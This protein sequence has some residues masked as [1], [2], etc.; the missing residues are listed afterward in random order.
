MAHLDHVSMDD[1]RETLGQIEDKVPAQRVLTAIAYKQGD[2]IG[3]L[4]ERHAVSRQ[5]IRNWVDR[6][7]QRPLDVAPF[8]EPRAGRPRKLSTTD[9]RRFQRE[10]QRSP[11]RVGYDADEWTPRLAQQHLE[12]TY[13]VAYSDRHVRRL[14][15]ESEMASPPRS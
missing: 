9:R 11:R 15:R 12:T 3:R 5:T 2:S 8:D 7:A 13:G 1:L 14:M 6:F 4:A 10:L